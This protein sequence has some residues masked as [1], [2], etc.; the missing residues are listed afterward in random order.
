[1]TEETKDRIPLWLYPSTIE[2]MDALLEKDNCKSRSEFIEKAIRFYSGY[3]SA[4]DS[5]K[6]LPTAITSAM[7]GIVGTS[8]NRIARV[9]FKLAVE[10]SM[11]MNILASNAEVDEALLRK[12]RG[13]CVSDVKKSIGSI[14]IED[15]MKF[16]KGE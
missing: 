3:I 5:M 2:S 11:M 1:M 14:N 12:L 13:K 16:Q 6:F 8:E 10:M 15:V 9:L 7:S 4:E